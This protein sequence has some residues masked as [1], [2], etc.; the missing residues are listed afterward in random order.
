MKKKTPRSSS[1]VKTSTSEGRPILD[2]LAAPPNPSVVERDGRLTLAIPLPPIVLEF[3]RAEGFEDVMEWISWR[4]REDQGGD[5][6]G[7]WIDTFVSRYEPI[8]AAAY[9]IEIGAGPLLTPFGNSLFPG[10][11]FGAEK[12]T[13]A[14]FD[15]VTK[16][17]WTPN[18]KQGYELSASDIERMKAMAEAALRHD[19]REVRRLAELIAVEW[20]LVPDGDHGWEIR[21]YAERRKKLGSKSAR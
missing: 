16:G 10:I 9:I 4:E 2:A 14:E 21:E 20:D 3:A 6:L 18:P 19:G 7:D 1:R 17:W 13:R 5:S 12:L 8:E 11:A 15:R